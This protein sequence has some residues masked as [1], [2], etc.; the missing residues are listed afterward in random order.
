LHDRVAEGE[1]QGGL[2]QADT[3]GALQIELDDY[4]R[5]F[6]SFTNRFR[7]PYEQSFSFDPLYYSLDI[8]RE[9][10]EPETLVMLCCVCAGCMP[11]MSMR[12]LRC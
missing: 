12:T 4:L 6:Q 11:G 2:G 1:A 7:A 8:G 5:R 3:L 9:W 10:H